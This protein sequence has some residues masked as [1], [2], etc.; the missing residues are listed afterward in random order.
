MSSGIVQRFAL[1]GVLMER[2][3]NGVKSN[4]A[5]KVVVG[6]LLIVLGFLTSTYRF[7]YIDFS[8]NSEL[9]SEW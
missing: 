9:F 4:L 1:F 2:N 8:I 6:V 3:V 5:F 7:T